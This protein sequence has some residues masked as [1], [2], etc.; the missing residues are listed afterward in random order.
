MPGTVLRTPL[1]FH[2][3]SFNPYNPK[4]LVLVLVPV[5]PKET[6]A[7]LP[8]FTLLELLHHK[9]LTLS[10]RHGTMWSIRK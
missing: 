5:D 9:V 4:R 1:V 8:D 7:C 3:N 2:I 6:E 10:D